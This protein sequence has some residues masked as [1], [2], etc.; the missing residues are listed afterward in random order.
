[1]SLALLLIKSKVETLS[2]TGLV[3]GI[4]TTDVTPPEMQLG[5]R[6]YN[7]LYIQ[8]LVHQQILSIYYPGIA[9]LFLQS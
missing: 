9:I 3:F 6:F 1:L 4:V 8:N 7:F 5:L 2:I